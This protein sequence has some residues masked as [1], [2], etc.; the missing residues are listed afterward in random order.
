MNL[1]AIETATDAVG[2]AFARDG[3]GHLGRPAR[4][5]PGP[6]RAARPRDRRR[7]AAPRG[8]RWLIWTWWRSTT[9]RGCSPDC[10]S[11]VATAKA[12]GRRLDRG[13]A[14]LQPRRAGRGRPRASPYRA[15]DDGGRAWSTRAAARSSSPPT[16]S[17]ADRVDDG[18][19]APDPADRSARTGAHPIAPDV[20][21][22]RWARSGGVRRR[23]VVGDG[24]AALPRPVGRGARRRPR[25]RRRARGAA[26]RRCLPA[27]LPTGW[28]RGRAL[29]RL[30]AVVPDYRREADARI[31]W[32]ERAPRRSARV[33]RPGPPVSAAQPAATTRRGGDRPHAHE[34]RAGGARHRAGGL[35]RAVVAPP[36]HRGARPAELPR[37]PCGLDRPRPGR[38]TGA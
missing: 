23:V 24:A 25:P 29:R 18:D 3:A 27:W 38:V 16:S 10:G 6:R 32:E 1:L 12:L 31:N 19:T 17:R 21:A 30:T 36:V 8:W 37:L 9:G 26:A 5:R 34:G 28:P 20:L 2:V 35:P 15:A 13:G 4:G 14:G 7:R 22:E 11:G 33:R